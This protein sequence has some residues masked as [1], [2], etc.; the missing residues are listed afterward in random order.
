MT[1]VTCHANSLLA[2]QIA[3]HGRL[4]TYRLRPYVWTSA[5]TPE[6]L[7]SSQHA[8]AECKINNI[9]EACRSAPQ[10]W[11]AAA[12][13]AAVV[14]RWQ[15][16]R[17]A[18]CPDSSGDCMHSATKASATSTP[19]S[20]PKSL[21]AQQDIDVNAAC[22][23]IGAACC[24]RYDATRC[25]NGT[26]LATHCMSA[27]CLLTL[28]MMVMMHISTRWRCQRLCVGRIGAMGSLAQ[29]STSEGKHRSQ[30]CA[31]LAGLRRSASSGE[32]A[33]RAGWSCAVPRSRSYAAA[34][35]LEGLHS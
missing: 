6:G 32:A 30:I 9:K 7:S 13:G 11:R 12:G 27:Q 33:T 34:L 14:Q 1:D 21:D 22:C 24:H 18:G 20:M 5:S 23:A 29:E 16:P 2:R 28:L 31:H 10:T 25:E 17:Q 35:E 15:R 26:T 19:Y 4:S 3:D 8:N